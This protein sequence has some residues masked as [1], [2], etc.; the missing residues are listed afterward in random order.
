MLLKVS[1]NSAVG[2]D[3]ELHDVY[4]KT[5][6]YVDRYNTMTNPEKN[7]KELVE[8]LDNLQE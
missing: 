5:Q 8:E 2:R 3:E 4:R 1:A 6:N 7:S